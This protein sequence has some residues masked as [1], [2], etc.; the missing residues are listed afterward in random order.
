MTNRE[1]QNATLNFQKVDRGAVVETFYPWRLTSQRY[2]TEGLPA[3]LC[4]NAFYA[5]NS[6]T[7]TFGGIHVGK[8]FAMD[9]GKHVMAYEQYLGFDAIRRVAFPLPLQC[10]EEKLIEETP[11]HVITQSKSGVQY[12][13]KT[14]GSVSC[15]HKHT[16][17]DPED[18]EQLKALAAKEIETY[19]TDEILTHLYAPLKEGHDRGDYTIRM[20]IMGF[21]WQ[22]RELLGDEEHLFA[23]YEEPELLHDIAN[24][25]CEFYE[26]RLM[27]VIR[28]L[29]PDVI[30]IQE[31]LSG[32]NGPMISGKHFDEFVGAYYKRIIPQFKAAGVQNVFVDTDGNF[33]KL[34]PNFMEAGVDGFLPMDVN[35]GM[36]IVKVRQDFP[37]LKFIGGYNKLMI[38]QGKEAIDAEFARILPV[39][40]GGG[41]LVGN[42]HQVPPSAPL[43]LYQ[44]YIE[45]L[46]EVMAQAGADL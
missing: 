9:W 37:T 45:R 31:D 27:P 2:K 3:E 15:V 24:F 11:S 40:R 22:G 32:K 35:A 29:Q 8:Y 42:D 5:A 16:I 44:Y 17:I 23:F 7:E 19:F 26:S 1:R 21:F 6:P 30:Y 4:D 38:E 34:I 14:G 28:L 33:A 36:D 46:K 10:F 43:E 41:Y 12:I 25:L 39:V 18:W 20:N 13:R